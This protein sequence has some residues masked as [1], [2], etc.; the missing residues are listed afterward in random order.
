MN[1]L[2]AIMRRG[3]VVQLF[4]VALSLVFGGSLASAA[5]TFAPRAAYHTGTGPT[6]PA[7]ADLNAD[8]ILDVAWVNYDH[9]P[10]TVSVALGTGGGVF[11]ARTDYTVGTKP[12]TV[13]IGD[14]N[15]DSVPDLVVSNWD[16]ANL[17]VLLGSGGGAFGAA[18][19]YT[20]G[21]RPI[22]GRL[23]D[24]NGDGHLDV[25]VASWTSNVILR[26]L[27][28]GSG[29]LGFPTGY[30]AG[31]RPY[32]VAL[33]DLN[34]DGRLDVVT[35]NRSTS[36]I[37]VLLGTVGGGFGAASTVAV[38]SD[39]VWVSLSDVNADGSLDALVANYA[40]NTVS[41]V[42]G[43]GSGGFGARTDYTTGV[44]P[45]SVEASDFDLDGQKDL[46][47][48][49]YADQTVSILAG[50][51]GGTFAPRVTVATGAGP[52][53]MAVADV[54][55]DGR[56]DLL[57]PCALVDSL[58]VHLAAHSCGGQNVVV[59]L[60][61]GVLTITGTP[62]DDDVR[63]SLAPGGAT[64]QVDDRA[65]G[66]GVDYSHPFAS[67]TSVS[68]TLGDGAD[69]VIC[70]DTNGSIALQRQMTVDVGDGDNVVVSTTGTM[71]AGEVANIDATIGS[72]RTV[73]NGVAN[74]R[75]MADA[76]RDNAAARGVQ[77]EALRQSASALIGEAQA[78][79]VQAQ[80]DSAAIGT[81]LLPYSVQLQN[82]RDAMVNLAAAF[83]QRVLQFTDTTTTVPDFL[84]R[85]LTDT[86]EMMIDSL[87]CGAA[88]RPASARRAGMNFPAPCDSLQDERLDAEVDEFIASADSIADDAESQFGEQA[89][90]FEV[91]AAA[92]EAEGDAYLLRVQAQEAAGDLLNEHA[93]VDLQAD[94]DNFQDGMDALESQGDALEAAAAALV[95]QVLG[96]ID[97][98]LNDSAS[99][100]AT[101]IQAVT[102]DCDPSTF[103]TFIGAGILI[104]TPLN[105]H[106][107]GSPGTDFMFGGGGQDK[108]D[109]NG[110]FD[111]IFG[112]RGDDDLEGGDGYDILIGWKGDDCMDGG[113]DSDLLFGGLGDDLL[114]GYRDQPAASCFHVHIPI[115]EVDFELGD[116]L[117]GGDG[118][119]TIHGSDCIDLI[120]GR[121][122][123]DDIA[124]NDG[125]DFI[126][127]GTEN[128]LV[129]SGA[130]GGFKITG[131]PVSPPLGDFVFGGTGDDGLSGGEDIDLIWGRAGNDRINGGDQFDLAFGGED[132]DTLHGDDGVDVLF[133][134]PAADVVHGDDDPD[135][136]FGGAAADSVCGDDSV[137]F[138]FGNIDGD[139]MSGGAGLD[140]IFGNGAADIIHGD[141]GVDFVFGGPDD[142]TIH[143]DGSVDV[144]FGG[145]GEDVMDGGD[146]IDVM[147]G[148]DDND[149]MYGGIGIDL[150]FGNLGLDHMEG[151]GDIDLVFGGLDD[152]TLHGNGETDLLAGGAGFDT[153][154]GGD[155][156]DVL[157][158]NAQNDYL[159]GEAG[160]D[161]MLG[162]GGNDRMWGGDLADVMLG[163]DEYD[164]MY[165]EASFDIMLGNAHNDLME[166]GDFADL[167]IGSAGEDAVSGGPGIDLLFGGAGVDCIHGNENADL[168]FGNDGN[169]RAFGDSGN[170][171]VFGCGDADCLDGGDQADA[172]FGNSGADEVDGGSGGD[173]VFGNQDADTMNGDD[174]DDY[175]FGGRGGDTMFGGFG[176]DILFGNKE[177]DYLY[178]GSGWDWCFGGKGGAS[179][180]GNGLEQSTPHGCAACNSSTAQLAGSKFDDRNSNGAWDS[181]EPGLPGWHINYSGPASGTA[182]TG[183]NGSY[184]ITGLP[185][186]VYTVCEEQRPN[187]TQTT[188]GGCYTR[189][190]GMGETVTGLDFGNS[191]CGGVANGVHGIDWL[192]DAFPFNITAGLP[193]TAA[194]DTATALV[195][196]GRNIA[197][198]MGTS[199]RFNIAG[200]SLVVCA[201]GDSTRV[202]LVFRILPGPGNYRISAGRS[203]P[204]TPTMQLLR[205]PTNQ[206]S[207]ATP[208]DASFWGQYLA[209]N[210]MFGT[211]GGHVGGRWN[212]NVWNSARL[213]TAEMNLFPVERLGDLTQLN[214]CLWMGT[215][216]ESDPK[217]MT[218]GIPRFQCYVVDTLY[219]ATSSPLRNNVTCNASVPAWLTTLPPTYTGWSGSNTTRE[220]SKIIPDGLLTPGAHVQYFIR[221][222]HIANPAAYA[223]V[224][225]TTRVTPQPDEIATVGDVCTPA[226]GGSLDGHRWQRFGVLP[227]R[228]KNPAFGGAGMAVMLY[229]DLADGRGEEL[230]W[231]RIAGQIGAT[232][233]NKYGAHNGWHTSTLTADPNDPANFV[234]SHRGQAGTTWDL[235]DVQLADDLLG[236]WAGSPGGR[237]SVPAT[238]FASGKDA[239]IGPTPEMLR[240]YY[241]QV[242]ATTADR[243]TGLLGPFVDRSQN[244]VMV[245]REFLS[246][247][248]G[249]ARPRALQIMGSNFVESETA[250]N[251][252][253]H[254]ALLS[255]SLGVALRSASYRA[256]NGAS[257]PDLLE[258]GGAGGVFGV[259]NGLGTSND[260]L[261]VTGSGGSFGTTLYQ[262]VGGGAPYL[263]SVFHPSSGGEQW[264][265]LTHGF[266][267][268]DVMSRYCANESGR[269]SFMYNVLTGPLA[270]AGTSTGI[271]TDVEEPVVQATELRIH[272]NPAVRG[273]AVVRFS[274]ARDD[275]G[276][277]VVF[278]VA[279]RRTRELAVGRIVAGV[280]Q[281]SWDGTDSKG[282]RMPA[283]VYFVRARLQG[284]HYEDRK[285]LVMLN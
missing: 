110:G 177:Y 254:T 140:L 151:Q 252:G 237:F 108:M 158:G 216:H 2:A 64:L 280:H 93:T 135:L 230:E 146:F 178:G 196:T 269:R 251:D 143:G 69:E 194:F 284:A 240:A 74:L 36:N 14:L 247:P 165:G 261:D 136:A 125:M 68:I 214:C 79:M 82:Q 209:D 67:V 126:F 128:D 164:T 106:L 19:S 47:V 233:P 208:G 27:G 75:A 9:S 31:T 184:V 210:G 24:V 162:N 99:P 226:A 234:R 270:S 260:V 96:L 223:L 70:D 181:G 155:G 262:G 130:G 225:D 274:V 42:P 76:L 33:G 101:G 127:G 12:V 283:G 100:E 258:V 232:A 77:G 78:M 30:A 266:A 98:I 17:S 90:S 92:A 85:V 285:V 219:P 97:G 206:S 249:T 221:R 279:G 20:A 72:L 63:L 44:Q 231:T 8:G 183:A 65:N 264:M 32:G 55:G 199:G 213:D 139:L 86:T 167:V 53:R 218:L 105:D 94:A 190:I 186:G 5:P 217:Y 138:L 45:L 83:Q 118:S 22:C 275:V 1:R 80:L 176:R 244:D 11:A 60:S 133:G 198:L 268:R 115:I 13:A 88:P 18:T 26:L 245:L 185:A 49:D 168:A 212:E 202:D 61:G 41:V 109:G 81:D 273:Q 59:T 102:A 160:I 241:R 21:S 256:W 174:D 205:L 142:D 35:T 29:G 71:T 123:A 103:L 159:Y 84:A 281:L 104:G 116:F 238:G 163:G 16:S 122:G 23:A 235:Y 257:C 153:V 129:A 57:V 267:L 51:G 171:L 255:L 40:S 156:I 278:D 246:Q 157:L 173:F 161:I 52:T 259:Q 95:A 203:F 121:A 191:H 7:V 263:A 179:I 228:W 282:S 6:S 39:P 112:G 15:H 91:L 10:G 148:W 25:I 132:A 3:W 169:D 229:L 248:S 119:D 271:T 215:Y 207:V 277:V 180:N 50:T 242:F 58:A 172:V 34:G 38:G 182:T 28:N 152:D 137:D 195:K 114:D 89:A 197:Q 201:C 124:G 37:S 154:H 253:V 166:G 265:G 227:D 113:G 220:G 236:G 141:D 131:T 147:F 144:L 4:A 243:A 250:L 189:K 111:F 204:T 46:S 211:P 188:P 87:D 145:V 73:L 134:G 150:M 107:I 170:D 117:W 222:S 48:T 56:A 175:M 149:T 272:R 120:F 66:I 193:G 62:C 276:E 200:D 224:P 239:R 43:N 187:W 192:H 54:S